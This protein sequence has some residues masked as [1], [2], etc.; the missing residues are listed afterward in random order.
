MK[1]FEFKHTVSFEETNLV[2]NVYFAN[3]I[4]WQGLCREMFLSNRSDE[5]L[6]D[7]A[8]NLA[9]ITLNCSCNFYGELRAFDQVMICMYLENINQNKVKLKFEYFKLEDNSETLVALGM[10]EI[11]CFKREQHKMIPVE[12]PKYFVEEIALYN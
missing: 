10:H 8:N 12:V 1:R 5:V 6:E 11:G 2:G 4:K 3:Y 7:I 9:L